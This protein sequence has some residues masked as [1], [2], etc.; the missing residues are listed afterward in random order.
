MT[1]GERL[2]ALYTERADLLEQIQQTLTDPESAARFESIDR[3]R[4][5]GALG[6]VFSAAMPIKLKVDR[7][8]KEVDWTE[9]QILALLN[10]PALG[11]EEP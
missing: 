3:S 10:N 9:R 5:L 7:L 2:D 6:A 1:I 4:G 8:Q 11:K